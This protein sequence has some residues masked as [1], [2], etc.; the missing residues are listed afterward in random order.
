LSHSSFDRF[1]QPNNCR[2][3]IKTIYSWWTY[4]HLSNYIEML[5]W[6]CYSS[7]ELL[8]LYENYWNLWQQYYFLFFFLALKFVCFYYILYSMSFR[9]KQKYIDSTV[10]GVSTSISS[11][12]PSLNLVH[13]LRNPGRIFQ[14]PESQGSCQVLFRILLRILVIPVS[15]IFQGETRSCSEFLQDPAQIFFRVENTGS[16]QDLLKIL[17]R[18]LS[19]LW[20]RIRPRLFQVFVKIW[21][22]FLYQDPVS[23]DSHI[24]QRS[25]Q[26]NNKINHDTKLKDLANLWSGSWAELFKN[27]Y[28]KCFKRI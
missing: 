24:R 23:N 22:K 6:R 21:I 1:F 17:D 5:K 11:L 28:F 19:R 4:Q 26:E 2:I 13:S 16:Y 25:W 15:R 8:A 18:I 27:I 12:Y 3:E 20:K 14:D 9:I 7:F 10:S